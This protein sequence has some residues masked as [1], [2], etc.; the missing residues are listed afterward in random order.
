[1]GL[2]AQ[3]GELHPECVF[4]DLADVE[5]VQ[6]PI[7]QRHDYGPIAMSHSF[8]LTYKP[9]FEEENWLLEQALSGQRF[10]IK[11]VPYVVEIGYNSLAKEAAWRAQQPRHRSEFTKSQPSAKAR[12]AARKRAKAGRK[13]SR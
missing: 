2:A 9:T 10:E 6:A 4:I 11:P 8:D 7:H 3:L 13:A 1:M 5:V 12:K